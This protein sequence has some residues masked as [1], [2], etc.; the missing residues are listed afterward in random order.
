M[1]KVRMFKPRRSFK[2]LLQISRLVSDIYKCHTATEKHSNR[3][4]DYSVLWQDGWRNKDVI[5]TTQPLQQLW[6]KCFKGLR[7]FIYNDLGVHA[8][9]TRKKKKEKKVLTSHVI[10]IEHVL[11][12]RW[13]IKHWGCK[14]HTRFVNIINMGVV[15][16]S[17]L[18]SSTSGK[19]SYTCESKPCIEGLTELLSWLKNNNKMVAQM[20][21]FIFIGR[22]GGQG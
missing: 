15:S 8:A 2:N 12:L 1:S 19:K 14:L 16:T 22:Q 5:F 3:Q 7:S 6:M 18:S 21:T 11:G 9:T 10:C 17:Q 4:H 13:F 20:F